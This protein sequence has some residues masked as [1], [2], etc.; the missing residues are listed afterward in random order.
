MSSVT[1][2]PHTYFFGH[3]V[4]AGMELEF[5][6]DFAA[7]LEEL[8]TE[9][10][11]KPPAAL[12]P[13]PDALAAIADDRAYLYTELYSPLVHEAFLISAVVFLE[14]ELTIYTEG[15]A[16]A[17]GI[18][19]SLRDIAGSMLDRF[20][21]FCTKLAGLDPAPI[22]WEDM[23]GLVEIR[24]CLIH[25][26]GQLTGFARAGAI[27]AFARRHGV[28]EIIDSWIKLRAES[29]EV[30][31]RLLKGFVDSIYDDALRRFPKTGA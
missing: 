19:L 23:K 10:A 27:E 18:R 22:Y 3:L 25:N 2:P 17:L 29:P 4:D 30:I 9:A 1:L 7:R 31:L 20:R 11:A 8:L 15:L 28:P 12:P 6:G 24:N 13:M 16:A 26:S 14:R 21:T 5:L